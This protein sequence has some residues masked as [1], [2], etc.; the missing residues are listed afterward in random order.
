LQTGGLGYDPLQIGIVLAALGCFGAVGAF[1]AAP[2]AQRRLGTV[3]CYRFGCAAF[4]LSILCMP[5][6][7]ALAR[8]TNG[9]S[10]PVLAVLGLL[11]ALCIL[12]V[13]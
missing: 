12:A 9:T 8:R 5:L 4:P 11:A 7:N 6:A 10:W 13:R 3:N 1:W 2:L